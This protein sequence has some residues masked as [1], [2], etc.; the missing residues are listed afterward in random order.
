MGKVTLKDFSSIELDST[1]DWFKDAELKKYFLFRRELTKESHLNWFNSYKDDSTQKI[2]AIYHDNYHCGNCGL[3]NID[4]INLKAELWIYLGD[5]EQRGKGISKAA[6]KKLLAYCFEE[7]SLHKVYLHVAAF[8]TI[9]IKLY[10][11]LGF[12]EEG[13]F[14]DDYFNEGEFINIIRM[15]ILNK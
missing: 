5:K 15:Y 12:I 4:N 10:E 9:A 3:K 1:F 11:K 7:I 2:F 13:I 6:T 14:I 8:N